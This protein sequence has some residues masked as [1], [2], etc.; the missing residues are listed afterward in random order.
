MTDLTQTIAPKSD[1]LNADDLIGRSLTVTVTGV[2]L[3][4]EA[5]QPVAVEH[6]SGR[7]FKPCKSMRRVLVQIWGGDGSKYV[8]RK[9][10]LYRD[11]EVAFGGQKVGGIRISHMS[12]ID[13]AVTMALTASKAQRKP[14]TVKPLETAT[15]APAFDAPAFEAQVVARVETATVAGDLSAWWESV[16]P[17]RKKLAAADQDASGRLRALVAGKI[18]ELSAGGEI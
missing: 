18:G 2:K 1:Q 14:F 15:Q 9:M 11:P 13:K 16:T 6:D 7:P 17:E 10:T 5:D 4:G 3:L 12:G 8:G